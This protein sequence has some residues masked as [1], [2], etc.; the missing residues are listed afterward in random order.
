MY[1]QKN[2]LLAILYLAGVSKVTLSYGSR[3]DI[4]HRVASGLRTSPERFTRVIFFLV[5]EKDATR[6]FQVLKSVFGIE[7]VSAQQDSTRKFRGIFC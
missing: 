2:I 7:Q 5:D 4:L 6:H 3:Q 1:Q